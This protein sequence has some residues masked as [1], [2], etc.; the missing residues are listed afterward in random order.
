MNATAMLDLRQIAAAERPSRVLARFEALPI[1]G[2][3]DLEIDPQDLA[4]VGPQLEALWPGQFDWQALTG[5]RL[6]LSRKPAAK[7]GCCGCC[8]G[9][10]KSNAVA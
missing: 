7:S 2:W 1:G 6:R 4:A 9:G 5:E 8:G 10:A 3:L